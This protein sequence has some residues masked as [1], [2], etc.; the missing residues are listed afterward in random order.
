M[1]TKCKKYVYSAGTQTYHISP[2]IVMFVENCV[3][4]SKRERGNIKLNKPSRTCFFSFVVFSKSSI[5][6]CCE[7]ESG[8]FLYSEIQFSALLVTIYNS[9]SVFLHTN[10]FA[11]ANTLPLQMLHTL[12]IFSF[13]FVRLASGYFQLSTLFYSTFPIFFVK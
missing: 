10:R 4:Q 13:Y 7:C 9:F 1:P 12:L 5:G 8:C 2:K 3:G 11:L 6:V